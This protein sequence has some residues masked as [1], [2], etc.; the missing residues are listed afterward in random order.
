MTDDAVLHIRYLFPEDLWSQMTLLMYSGDE[1]AFPQ[2]IH[3][4][5]GEAGGTDPGFRFLLTVQVYCFGCVLLFCEVIVT[6][7]VALALGSATS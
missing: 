6:C 1:Y 5:E 7:S 4:W 3:R 2:S